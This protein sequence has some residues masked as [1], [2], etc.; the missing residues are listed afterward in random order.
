MF[1][2]WS[3]LIEFIV[4]VVSIFSVVRM[5]GV[6]VPVGSTSMVMAG[7][8]AIEESCDGMTTLLSG[9]SH[10]LV[11]CSP[12]LSLMNCCLML[13]NCSLCGVL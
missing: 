9:M 8:A 3:N 6:E 4:L 13:L 1:V 10:M 2:D 7:V 11:C 5:F 12:I